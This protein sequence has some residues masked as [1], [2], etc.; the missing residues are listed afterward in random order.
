MIDVFFD[1]VLVYSFLNIMMIC[2]LSFS[3]RKNLDDPVYIKNLLTNN[4][5][6]SKILSWLLFAPTI[7]FFESI[8]ILFSH[9]RWLLDENEFN[10]VECLICG[11]EIE[12]PS[13]PVHIY[14][15][16]GVREGYI[17]DSCNEN[18]IGM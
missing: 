16:W 1:L 5:K 7:F 9:N 8:E 10:K 12:N 4:D 11:S 15:G 13:T 2:G 17:C 3:I 6:I 18:D 14:G